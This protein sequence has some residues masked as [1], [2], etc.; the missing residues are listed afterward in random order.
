MKRQ[1][2]PYLKLLFIGLFFLMSCHEAEQISA[3]ESTPKIIRH[4][5]RIA[6]QSQPA[7]KKAESASLTINSS[8]KKLAS[9]DIT[10]KVNIDATKIQKKM[11]VQP[12][13]QIKPDNESQAGQPDRNKNQ[14]KKSQQAKSSPNKD[15]DKS[16]PPSETEMEVL[17]KKLAPKPFKYRPQGKVDPFLPLIAKKKK[18]TTVKSDIVQKAI[19]KKRTRILTLLEKFDLSQLKLTA[20]LRTPKSA[21]AIVEETSGRGFVVKTGTRIGLNSGRVVDILMDRIIIQETEEVIAGK[22]L[23]VTREMKLN[24]PDSEF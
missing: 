11:P 22:K 4:K 8:D 1:N 5:I 16:T 23:Y 6:A 9:R 17:L 10:D 14:D 15:A 18:T 3:P 7:T 2:Q 12:A 19:R 24:K 20:V 13:L 21:V